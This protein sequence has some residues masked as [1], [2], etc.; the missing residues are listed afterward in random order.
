MSPNGDEATLRR[1]GSVQ[2][3]TGPGSRGPALFQILAQSPHFH[4]HTMLNLLP[5]LEAQT[6]I[7]LTRVELNASTL[8][9]ATT[10]SMAGRP[11]SSGL[12][13]L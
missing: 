8:A 9:L 3:R 1:K 5:G 10:L 11:W 2:K 12:G 6:A 4:I 7:L 13:W